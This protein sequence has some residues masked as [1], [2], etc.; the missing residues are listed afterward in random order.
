MN[1]F[2]N[3]S[4]TII[5]V[6]SLVVIAS[7]FVLGIHNATLYEP[8]HGFDG[9]SHLYYINYLYKYG[10]IPTPQWELAGIYGET[11]Q[12]PLYYFFGSLLM[13]LTGTWKISQYMNIFVLWMIIGVVALALRKVFKKTI[14]IFIG[15]LSLAALPMLNIFP[16]MITNELLNTFWIIASFVICLF[17]IEDKKQEKLTE[18][19]ILLNIVLTLGY[20]TKIS[21]LLI[22][23]TVFLTFLIVFFNKKSNKKNLILYLIVSGLF[24]C[25]AAC[26]K[27]SD[28][29]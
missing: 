1:F 5:I 29:S 13:H 10:K 17:I 22:F 18:Y 11:H 24:I 2:K 3:R 25:A 4:R 26:I 15:S 7:S 14:Y 9:I 23:P 6:L 28:S 21:I 27:K 12:P 20:W 8:K 16:A 19:L